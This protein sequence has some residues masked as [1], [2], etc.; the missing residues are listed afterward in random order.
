MYLKQ[1][2]TK[3]SYFYEVTSVCSKCLPISSRHSW[4]HSSALP[5]FYLPS[6]IWKWQYKE[7]RPKSK[8]AS[9]IQ[10]FPSGKVQSMVEPSRMLLKDTPQKNPLIHISTASP[11]KF[12]AQ[13]MATDAWTHTSFWMRLL[14][15]AWSWSHSQSPP[16]QNS[17][18]REAHWIHLPGATTHPGATFYEKT[19]CKHQIATVNDQT[20]Y[21]LP[22]ANPC[23]LIA[24]WSK[25]LRITHNV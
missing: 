20:K 6:R 13:E 11:R 4:C 9:E 17:V 24:Q 5:A 23:V 22:L 10:L 25:H 8:S 19:G 21:G 18:A 15:R 12:Q 1:R 14:Q 16:F 2:H 3:T 7:V